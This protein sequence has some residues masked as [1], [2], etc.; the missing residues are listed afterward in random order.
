[1]TAALH[2]IAG[3]GTG[4]LATIAHPRNDAWSPEQLGALADAGVSV[5]V[6]ALTS[7]EQQGLGFGETADAA[8]EVGMDF[9]AFPTADDSI[10]RDEAT[11]VILL[12]GRLAANVRAGRLV[13]TQCFGGVGRSTLLACTTLVLLGVGPSEALR[14]VTGGSETPITRDWLYELAH[15][16][17]TQI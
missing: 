2:V 13:V 10:P 5:L 15:Q 3:H 17:T 7:G 9:M 12:A 4:Q 6:S 11:K 16:R 14:R 1:M 8:A